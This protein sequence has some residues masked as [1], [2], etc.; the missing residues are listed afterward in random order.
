MLQSETEHRDSM[1]L[2]ILGT[3]FVV[4]GLLVLVA[5][6]WTW[7]NMRATVVNLSCGVVLTSIGGAMYMVALKVGGRADD[8][9]VDAEGK[10]SQ[11]DAN[12]PYAAP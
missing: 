5:T 3:F 4:L 11:K 2:R 8:D 12:K 6:G 1:T 9:A 10:C 7:G